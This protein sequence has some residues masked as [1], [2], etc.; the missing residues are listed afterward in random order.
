MNPP[1]VKER[2]ERTAEGDFLLQIDLTVAVQLIVLLHE[3]RV[4][5]LTGRAVGRSVTTSDG[6]YIC[7]A[8]DFISEP[9]LAAMDAKREVSG[10]CA[11]LSL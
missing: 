6:L 4:E 8:S 10:N 7:Q 1:V 9:N 2:A 11:D 5:W 3:V